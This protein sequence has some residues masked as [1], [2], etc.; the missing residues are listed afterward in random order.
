V[1]LPIYDATLSFEYDVVVNS[2]TFK[3]YSGSTLI[4]Y[5]CVILNAFLKYNDVY[6]YEVTL[7][8]FYLSTMPCFNIVIYMLSF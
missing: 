8:Y 4:Y 2:I 1:C 7:N 3:R 6:N 5:V